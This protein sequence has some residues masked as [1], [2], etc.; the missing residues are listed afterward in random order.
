MASQQNSLGIQNARMHK[1]SNS[2]L[3]YDIGGL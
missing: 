2:K 3:C 1:A